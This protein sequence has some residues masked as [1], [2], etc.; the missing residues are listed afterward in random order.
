MCDK[1]ASF[2]RRAAA[3]TLLL[4]LLAGCAN[5][6]KGDGSGSG[7]D[8]GPGGGG[9]GDDS[10]IGNPIGPG[11]E[12]GI[13][14]FD[15]SISGGDTGSGVA[16]QLT[17]SPANPTITVTIVDGVVT[18][19]PTQQFTA[20]NGS[21]TVR[22][23]WSID[24]GAIASITQ[25]GVLT[26]TGTIAGAVQ[27]TAGYGAYTVSTT[28]TVVINNTQNGFTGAIDLTSAGGYGGV[29]GEG[30][31][32]PV[33][34]G[35]KATLQ[36]T[37]TADA[38]R[39]LLYPYNGTVW[40]RGLLAPLLQWTPGQADATAVAIHLASKTFVYD[41]YF[42]RPAA[43][44]S[45]SLFV[46]HPIPQDVWEQATDSTA[47]TDT[48]AVSVVL[49]QGGAAVGPLTESWH[50]APGRLQ[51]TVYYES[52]GTMLVKNSDFQAQGGGYVGAA[53]LSIKPGDTEPK[54]AAGN[55]TPTATL[56]SGVGCRACHSV[57][58]KGGSLIVQD[59]KYPYAQTSSYNLQT[60]AETLVNSPPP[61]NPP[62]PLSWAAL[63]PDG[64]Y[65][66][67]NGVWMG[68]DTDD[69][70]NSTTGKTELYQ[71]SASGTAAP[72]AVSGL[73]S[74]VAG[75]TPA[76]SPDGAHVAFTHVAGTLGTLTG[77][78]TH[79]VT[80]DFAA[81][82]A[83]GPTM[84]G[85]KNVFTTPAGKSDCVGFPSFLPTND[86]LLVQLTLMACGNGNRDGNTSFGQYIGTSKP[87]GAPGLP[88]EIWWTDVATATQHRLDALDGYDSTGKMYL[89][90]G[91]NGH[92]ADTQLNFEP[93]VSPS[94]SGGYAWV[95][96][97]SR[98]LYGNV[99]TIDPFSSDPRNYDY[100]HQVTTKKLWV[101]AIDLN[102]P[103]GTDPSHP[104]F[105]L[106]AQELQ[107]GN[108]RG[109]W[110]FEPC[111]GSG[112][113]CELGD[114][115]CGGYCTQTEEAGALMCGTTT[116]TCPRIGDKCEMSSQCCDMTAQCINGI[117][118]M[119]TPPIAK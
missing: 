116:T 86:A 44:A 4:S 40:P 36:K 46:R 38:S 60:L 55:N 102:A 66:L 3:W 29:G 53:V 15:S 47:G 96:F 91:P 77:D 39:S 45:T 80:L 31:G 19:A 14:V 95:V 35:D 63:S 110:V 50:V 115:C 64:T 109:F 52:Y 5:A 24:Q 87:D 73:P 58:A 103:A 17:I 20:M 11:G 78:G 118:S 106:P 119:P 104:A 30:P 6:G 10:S 114:Q 74:T 72:V 112:V 111:R 32:G 97:T 75:A 57:A 54:V 25:D 61:S 93:T 59:D 79:V 105:Y 84:S 34:D 18:N 98:R 33:S 13:F 42:G 9:G 56:G 67:T 85:A 76:F 23:G 65:A 37:P 82:A 12:G 21:Q 1:L 8:G 101:A 26:P 49:L 99:A 68:A 71:F 16:G 88:S 51:G 108:A 7:D 117:C 43:L 107:A 90:T 41:G 28:C 69:P 83:G 113:G 70:N 94:P 100:L 48:L 89:P 92:S 27:V 22:A 81:N 62:Y 2:S